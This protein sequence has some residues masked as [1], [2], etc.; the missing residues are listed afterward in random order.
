MGDKRWPKAQKLSETG[1][2]KSNLTLVRPYFRMYTQITLVRTC[3]NIF[4]NS[5]N[6]IEP[7]FT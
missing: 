1:K 7:V 4:R 6:P 3:C 5:I 2:H